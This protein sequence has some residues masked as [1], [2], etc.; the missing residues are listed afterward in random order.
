MGQEYANTFDTLFNT[1]VSKTI[2]FDKLKLLKTF[3]DYFDDELYAPSNKYKLLRKEHIRVL[4]TIRSNLTEVQ[5]QL[6]DKSLEIGNEM[7]EEEEYQLFLYGILIGFKLKQ[8][9]EM[10]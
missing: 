8:E 2:N 1:D 6:L 3:F 4:N 10:E 9:L 5:S 7:V